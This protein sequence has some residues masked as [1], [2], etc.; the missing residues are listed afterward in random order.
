L[1]LAEVARVL[2]GDAPLLG[3]AL[4]AH[5]A[6]LEARA[7]HLHDT[8]HKVRKLR[9]ELD[10][11]TMSVA[12]VVSSVRRAENQISVTFELPWPWGGEPFELRGLRGL[13][14]IT[15][16]LGSGKTRL[17]M[18][19]AEKIPGASFVSEDRL[20]DGAA[21]AKEALAA[22]PELAARVRRS[23]SEIVQAG[24]NDCS[25]L[26]ALLTALEAEGATVHVVD[27]LESGLDEAT[28]EA[29]ICFLRRRAPDARPL[30]ALTRSTSILDVELVGPDE[31]IILCPANHSPPMP[32]APVRG[33]PGYEALATCLAAPA[34]R[35]RTEGVVAIRRRA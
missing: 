22:Q 7:R 15:G 4:A 25:A 33:A 18:R 26:L 29:L 13:T 9:A 14:F 32:V 23:I 35:A 31:A 21:A 5:E 19:M 28:Q 3:R 24:G 16:P 27:M 11:G 20:I 12:N 6:A 2:G 34:V 1:S 8:V 17:A 30:I 10:R